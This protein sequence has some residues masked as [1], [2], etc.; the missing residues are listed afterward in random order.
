M[1]GI[2]LF[3][4]LAALGQPAAA[5]DTIR[6][7]G[8]LPLCA[9]Q[10]ASQNSPVTPAADP[11]ATEPQEITIYLGGAHKKA[12]A[13]ALFAAADAGTPVTGL[14]DFDSLSST[15][16]LIGIYH[17]RMS[18]LYY[19]NHFRLT[20]PPA[21]DVAT[22]AGAYGN[23]SYL[24]VKMER[25]DVKG[26]GKRIA[27]K[28]RAGVLKGS[29]FGLAS[30]SLMM[31]IVSPGADGLGQPVIFYAFGYIGY[32]VGTAVGV[33]QVDPHDLF[34]AS[35]MGSLLG[36]ISGIGL[37]AITGGNRHV[38]FVCP[39]ASL[40]LAVWLSEESR[41][42]RLAKLTLKPPEISRF[43]IGLAPSPRGHLLAVAKL[44][45]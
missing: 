34:A 9:M 21:A 38:L 27:K 15:Y 26:T 33:S 12:V 14:A 3:L 25:G 18:P 39:V 2:L 17:S 37:A 10:G 24:S 43:S 20:F 19:G 5:G 44:R 41:N 1:R 28:L 42:R 23:L 7:A 30:G 40:A 29:A 11:E 35:L 13:P 22:I 45:F 32:T 16:S 31:G 4:V 36:N 6:A 8:L